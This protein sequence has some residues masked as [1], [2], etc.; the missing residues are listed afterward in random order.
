[1]KLRCMGDGNACARCE[2]SGL[3]CEDAPTKRR[4]MGNGS[5]VTPSSRT[6]ETT[7][8]VATVSENEVSESVAHLAPLPGAVPNTGERLPDVSNAD[9]STAHLAA[10]PEPSII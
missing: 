8:S 6:G 1:M 4:R 9:A 2:G 7:K 10:C 5:R 3:I